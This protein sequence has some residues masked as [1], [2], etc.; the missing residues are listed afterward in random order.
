MD[1]LQTLREK[2]NPENNVFPN[3]RTGNIPDSGVTTAKINDGAITSAKIASSAVT[4]AKIGSNAVTTGK[5]ADSAITNGKLAN[6]SVSLSK[7]GIS[8]GTLPTA[9]LQIDNSLLH[10]MN[11]DGVEGTIAD[12][13][14]WFFNMMNNPR[15]VRFFALSSDGLTAFD[16][17]VIGVEKRTGFETLIYDVNE[18]TATIDTDA[19]ALT[20]YTT[21]KDR[22]FAVVL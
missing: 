20:F 15:F 19:D 14:E 13:C 12:V 2:D 5:I 18:T 7:L 1:K 16:F 10:N 9:L 22:L 17:R 4:S 21:H 3:I 6:S 8:N 11:D